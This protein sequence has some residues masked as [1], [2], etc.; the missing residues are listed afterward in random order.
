MSKGLEMTAVTSAQ[1]RQNAQT[2]YESLR[3]KRTTPKTSIHRIFVSAYPFGLVDSKPLDILKKAGCKVVLNPYKRKIKPEEE[4]DL[5]QG[6]DGLIAGTEALNGEVL[7][8]ADQLRVISRVG[9]GLDG[10][11]FSVARER[12]IVV[13]YTPH[14]PALAV[15]ELTIGMIL[16]L[17]RMITKADRDIRKGIWSKYM[18]RLL[19]EQTV[20]I[21]GM[22]RIGSRVARLLSAFGCHILAHDLDPNLTLSDM[23]SIEWVSLKNLL[24]KSDFVTLH[25]PLTDKTYHLIN[26][27]TLSLMKPTAFLIN[28]SRGPVVD[29]AALEQSLRNEII[30]GAAI[31]VYEREPYSGPLLH[32]EKAVLTCHMGAAT[33]RSRYLME[34]QAAEDCLRV[35]QGKRPKDPILM[36]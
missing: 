27:A 33:T 14:A 20:G 4:K 26:V 25:V 1:Q 15:A 17:A 31:D 21:I 30:A 23:F 19:S 32:Q 22:G 3:P 2:G 29:E 6:I 34:L 11:D 18:G 28:T 12:G 7:D 8:R 36:I 5:L 24:K 16:D 9:V 13:T 35:L 10:I